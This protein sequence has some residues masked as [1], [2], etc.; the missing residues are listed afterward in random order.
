MTIIDKS[1]KTLKFLRGVSH[2]FF[3]S[4]ATHTHTQM[5]RQF[6]SLGTK[7]FVQEIGKKPNSN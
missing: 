4:S 1:D 5:K 6:V 3:L 7:D 2:I